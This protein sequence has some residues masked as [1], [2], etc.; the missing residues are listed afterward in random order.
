MEKGGRVVEMDELDGT[1]E[2]AS[3]REEVYER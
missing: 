3:V 1:I 2:V